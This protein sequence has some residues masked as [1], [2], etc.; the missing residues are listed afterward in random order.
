LEHKDEDIY[1]GTGFQVWQSI[2]DGY[3]TPTVPPTNDKAVKLGENNSK[4]INALLNGL[5]DTV[6][7]KVAHCKSA[8]EI[9]DKLRNIYEGDSKVKAAKLQTYR[10]QFEQLKMKEDEDIT[11]YFLRVD[12]I[13]NA[14]IGLGEE[15]EE[16]VIVQKV[17]RSLPMRFNPK[18]SALEERSDLNS[19]SM[20]ELHGIFIAY[21]MRTEQENPD[22]KEAAF[23]ASKISKQK[24]KEQEEYSS[25]RRLGR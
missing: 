24:K 10:G 8:K 22:V 23:K 15:I 6:F 20:D 2:V 25:S 1:T 16:S 21:E 14:I 3:T 9:W 12:E 18:I 5:S 19:I 7:T 17:L 11:T 4:A 13:V